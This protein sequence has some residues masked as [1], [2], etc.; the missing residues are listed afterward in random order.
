MVTQDLN[1]KLKESLN[2]LMNLNILLVTV[3]VA[4]ALKTKY[5]LLVLLDLED[6]FQRQPLTHQQNKIFQSGHFQRHHDQKL[7]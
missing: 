1:I 4:Q 3:V 6:M 7:Q 5:Q 2:L